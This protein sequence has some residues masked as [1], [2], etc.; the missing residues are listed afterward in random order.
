[1]LRIIIS[2]MLL[3]FVMAGCAET[4]EPKEPEATNT[5]ATTTDTD[6]VAMTDAEKRAYALG[7]NSAG[8]LVRSFPE[9]EQ[10]GIDVDKALVK[11]GFVDMLEDKP[12]LN[13]QEMQTILMAFQTELQ[14]KVAEIEAEQKQKSEEANATYLKSHAEMDGVT[15]TESGLQYRMLVE[16]T[17]AS[18]KS[19]DVVLVNYKGTLIDGTEFDSSYS[20]GEPLQFEVDRVIPGWAEGITLVKEGGKIELVMGPDLGYGSNATPT[21]P[22]YSALT[23]E[24]ELLKVN[25][26]PEVEE[27]EKSEAGGGN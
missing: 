16:G 25:P 8:F 15:I 21:I 11:Q 3:T 17:G 24:V 27:G 12:K 14:N 18:P 20:R 5:E 1:M 2:L 26:E 9:F 7:A 4:P 19:G 13:P 22:A 10:W 6:N 23:F